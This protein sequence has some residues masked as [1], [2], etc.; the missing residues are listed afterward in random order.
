MSRLCHEYVQCGVHST[1]CAIWGVATCDTIIKEMCDRAVRMHKVVPKVAQGQCTLLHHTISHAH[2]TTNAKD[3][4]CFAVFSGRCEPH[5][6][7][8]P[9]QFVNKPGH[10]MH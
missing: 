10:M 4:N 2:K 3:P 6:I 1:P 9:N 8:D 5:C 7:P